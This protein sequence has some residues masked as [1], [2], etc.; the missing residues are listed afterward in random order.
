MLTMPGRKIAIGKNSSVTISASGDIE[1][2]PSI[3]G[4]VAVQPSDGVVQRISYLPS[5]EALASALPWSGGDLEE[6][7]GAR[8]K[9]AASGAEALINSLAVAFAPAAD[10]GGYFKLMLFEGHAEVQVEDEAPI[11]LQPN[12]MSQAKVEKGGEM[13]GE[14][15]CD[16]FNL[17]VAVETSA[18]INDFRECW[19][20]GPVERE[21][22][23]QKEEIR[24][25]DYLSFRDGQR[26]RSPRQAVEDR[27]TVR[28]LRKG[29]HGG[30]H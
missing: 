5:T 2:E 4:A 19:D 21:I 12:E 15:R 24:R 16:A 6:A 7:A 28:S 8:S 22:E 29:L 1:L 25:G 27:Q 10:R 26:R 17:E 30:K 11:Q 3:G 20:M 9:I 18:L 23:R 13:D 14:I